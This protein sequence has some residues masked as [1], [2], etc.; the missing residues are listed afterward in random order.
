MSSI[1]NKNKRST[2]AYFSNTSPFVLSGKLRKSRASCWKQT[3]DYGSL[4][5]L[6]GNKL[7][8]TEVSRKLRET[9]GGRRKSRASCGK[10][11]S[12]IQKQLIFKNHLNNPV[13][14]SENQSVFI[15]PV[16]DM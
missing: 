10:Q 9:N 16:A 12:P 1:R 4:A 14:F 7:R 3:A 6:A 13:F 8:T 2:I 11:N 5:Q 15:N